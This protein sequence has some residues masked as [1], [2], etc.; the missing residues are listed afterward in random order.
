MAFDQATRNLLARFVSQARDLLSEE[1][2]RQLQNDYGLDPATGEVTTL[3]KL[4]QLDDT[5]RQTAQLL[6]DTLEHYLAGSE[7]TGQTGRREVLRR[8]VR[9]QAFTVLNRLCALRMAESRGLLTESIAKGHNS[10][11]FQ[12]YS[13]IAST[14]LGELGN[15]YKAYLFGLFDEFAI[16]LPVLF[17]RFSPQG[18]LF[19]RDAVLLQVLDLINQ[20]EID[21]LWAEDETI[22]WIYQY[23]NTKEERRAM[24]DASS[25][26]RNS[27]ELAVRNQFFTPRYV[28]E[29]LT[30]NTLGRIWYEM[31]Q[32]K[33][34]LKDECQYLV[35]RPNE[36]FLQPGEEA[37]EQGEQEG[38]SQEELLQQ[39]V[40]IAHRP[41][42]DP[43]EIRMLDPACGSMHFGLYAFDLFERIYD[44]AWDLDVGALRTDFPEKEDL[45]REVPRLIIEHNIHG[46]DIDPRAVQIAGLSLWLR[47]QRT[48]HEM[49]VSAVQRPRI[50]RSNIVCAEPM[51]GN[52]EMLEAFVS[53]LDMPLLGE[54]VKIVFE[55]MKLAGEAGALLKIEEEIREAID[56]ARQAWE[57]LE[58]KPRE[59]FSQEELNR[60]STQP[61]LTLIE[62]SLRAGSKS[63]TGEFWESIEQEVIDAL[64]V[65]A[66]Q[67]DVSAYQLRLFADD[68]ARGFAFIDLCRRRYDIAL[69]N[70]PFGDP[71]KGSKAYLENNYLGQPFELYANFIER[72]AAI[73]N[74]IGAITSHTFLTYGSLSNYRKRVLMPTTQMRLL[75][76]FGLGVMDA[77]MVRAAAYVVDRTQ[78]G[79]DGI[80]FRLIEDEN[81]NASLELC[82][83]LLGEGKP[84]QRR[85]VTK[86]AAFLKTE[87]CS[88]AYWAES[89]L[90]FFK[91]EKAIGE[92][93]ADILLGVVTSGNDQYLRLMWEVC[94][95]TIRNDGWVF[96]CKGGD[97]QKYFR[98]PHL[99]IDWRK[100]GSH[101]A[102][103]NSSAVRLRDT[104]Q[105]FRPGLTF[106]LVNEFGISVSV[107]PGNCIFDNGSPAVFSKK[108]ENKWVLLGLLNSRA[109]EFFIRCLT[110]TRHWQV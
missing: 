88:Y 41:M 42:K 70:P 82:L 23:W 57:K 39:T 107:L 97:F 80:Y 78:T 76:D 22:G 74:Y 50:L 59:L 11:G 79:G 75:A 64:R 19:P 21:A 53:T 65:Y 4:P 85:F 68:A 73:S 46:I 95:T 81:K 101:I 91:P 49:E 61:E 109:G 92:V 77:A 1:F 63:P 8:I 6:R 12:L 45:L 84:D 47:A 17:D 25:A 7:S 18:R 56:E 9:E 86:Q 62:K 55:K 36:V 103:G 60:I 16:D 33:T 71:A 15:A 99:V 102:I 40:H 35:R 105:Y 108:S 90:D 32:G 37:P 100:E 3:S 31:T 104:R 26:P 72:A 27:R 83:R 89:L 13:P 93:V 44:E 14:A 66:E 38:L 29:F 51:P 5:R 98:A 87:Q 30:D 58:R 110:S 34:R 94:S 28:V 43:R 24:R 54:L 48:W 106:P 96:Y 69:M 2:T 20:V 67:A 10:E 52:Q